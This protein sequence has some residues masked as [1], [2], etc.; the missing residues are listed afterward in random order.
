M[1]LLGGL[2]CLV[3]LLLTALSVLAWRTPQRPR[4]RLTRP[5][6]LVAVLVVEGVGTG[7]VAL[8]GALGSPLSPPWSWFAVVLGVSASLLCGGVVTRC[9]LALADVPSRPEG[10]RVQRTILR[11]GTWIGALERLAVTATVVAGWPEGLAAVVA[12][13]AFAR[14]PELR[15]SPTTGAVERFII[16]T[17]TSLGWA[18][19]CAGTIAVLT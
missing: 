17:F 12:V 6:T 13:K 19:V 1:T 11:G 7:V 8:L 16:G 2:A 3:W 14:Y 15:A 18:A 5:P 10:A 4:S 9:V